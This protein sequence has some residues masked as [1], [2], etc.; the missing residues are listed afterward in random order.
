MGSVAT[1]WRR[2]PPSSVSPAPP[3]TGIWPS[4]KL[5][6]RLL[7]ADGQPDWW[8]CSARRFDRLVG[9]RLRAAHEMQRLTPRAVEVLSAGRFKPVT[10]RS[11]ET[12]SRS[13]TVEKAAELA[14]LYGVSLAELLQPADV[15]G[16][17]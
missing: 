17:G 9:R 7:A 12:G 2:S 5:A 4:L 8:L 6:T 1:R 16:A 3:S 11:Y 15:D 14:A 10:L 13:L